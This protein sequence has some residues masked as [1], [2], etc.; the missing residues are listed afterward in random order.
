M[1]KEDRKRRVKKRRRVKTRGAKTR[2]KFARDRWWVGAQKRQLC[3]EIPKL[4]RVTDG[5]GARKVSV[6]IGA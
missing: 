2:P 3:C 5:V 1:D 6:Q 4:A